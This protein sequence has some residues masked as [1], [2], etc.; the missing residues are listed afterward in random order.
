MV[1]TIGPINCIEGNFDMPP[2]SSRPRMDSSRNARS[3]SSCSR[4]KSFARQRVTFLL[5]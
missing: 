1:P 3:V 2:A 4:R 5:S